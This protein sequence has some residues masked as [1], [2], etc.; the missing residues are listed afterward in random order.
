[1]ISLAD[2][3]ATPTEDEILAELLDF[4]DSLGFA[5]SSWQV[6]SW[7]RHLVQLV[8]HVYSDL[9]VTVSDIAAL[10]FVQ[11]SSGNAAT[12]IASELYGVDRVAALPTQGEIVLTSTA[13]APPHVIAVGQLQVADAATAP[14]RTYRNTSGGVLAPGGTLTLA[15]EAETAGTA[16]NIATGAMLYLWTPLVGVT[17]TNPAI[18]ATS[19]WITR[20]GTDEESDAL[21][22]ARAIGQWTLLAYSVTEGAYAVWALEAGSSVT[23]VRVRGDNPLGPGSVDVILAGPGGTVSAGVVT[24][25]TDYINGTDGIGRRPLNDVP[26][27][28]AAVVLGQAFDGTVTV[29]AS[30]QSV[31]TIAAIQAAISAYLSGVPIGGTVIPPGA[32][33]VAGVLVR[34]E[35]IAAVMALE[36]VLN[37][38]LTAPAADVIYPDIDRV[39]VPSYAGL[40]V[41]YV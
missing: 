4:L 15:W 37:F 33:G 39:L 11:L 34:A 29:S 23:R 8:A 18:G 36:G 10:G 12:L 30:A 2:L 21:L 19:T 35:V 5:G 7:Q 41:T 40:T 24:T 16:G 27:V 14:A 6:G 9:A 26:S 28:R 38:S 31:T 3:L 22:T 25:V 32:P 17:A 13:G 1:V 20:Y